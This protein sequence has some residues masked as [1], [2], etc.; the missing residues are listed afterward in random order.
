MGIKIN[1]NTSISFDIK[2]LECNSSR[3]IHHNRN[4]VHATKRYC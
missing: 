3:F 2:K 1:E 4:V